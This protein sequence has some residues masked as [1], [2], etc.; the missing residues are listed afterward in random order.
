MF[1]AT[2]TITYGSPPATLGIVFVVLTLAAV[3]GNVVGYWI[4]VHR[5]PAAV[6]AAHE[7]DRAASCSRHST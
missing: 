6:Q 2:G 4:R 7:L 5:R 3:L 1:T